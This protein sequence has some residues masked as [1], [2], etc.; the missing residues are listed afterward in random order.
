M[1]HRAAEAG[2]SGAVGFLCI[3]L[4]AISARRGFLRGVIKY[5]LPLLVS[6]TIVLCLLVVASVWLRPSYVNRT[7][8]DATALQTAVHIYMA[9]RPSAHCPSLRDLTRAGILDGSRRTRDE[10]GHPFLIECGGE[11]MSV[12]SV[13]PDGQRGTA[14]DMRTSPW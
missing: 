1:I 4:G 3:M 13:G 10:W 8:S 12:S 7:R 5:R 11:G 6:L 9:T 14:D 2:L